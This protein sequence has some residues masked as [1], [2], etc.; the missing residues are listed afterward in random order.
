MSSFLNSYLV[1]S[2][3]AGYI[4]LEILPLG[5]LTSFTSFT[6]YLI[7]FLSSFFLSSGYLGLVS[8]L[9]GFLESA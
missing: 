3:T 2:F 6:Y 8:S 1:G 5:S 9:P 4:D 7:A